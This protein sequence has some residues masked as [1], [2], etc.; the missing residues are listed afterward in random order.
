MTHSSTS[1][2]G[3]A[4]IEKIRTRWDSFRKL[5]NRP[6]VR[7]L[8]LMAVIGGMFA[9]M[10]WLFHE[11]MLLTNEVVAAET[12]I[13][14]VETQVA[15]TYVTRIVECEE[16][17]ESEVARIA[18]MLGAPTSCPLISTTLA[19]T[20]MPSPVLTATPTPPTPTATPTSPT[21][22]ATP[23]PPTPTDTPTPT[24]TPTNTPTPPTPEVLVITPDSMTC[25]P[26]SS[27]R[28]TVVIT[29]DNFIPAPLPIVKLRDIPATVLTAITQ[30]ITATIPY[31]MAPGPCNLTVIN[32][33]GGSNVLQDAFT[34]YAPEPSDPD[35][36]STLESS[37][38]VTFG[39][40]ADQ[41]LGD[42]DKVQLL[43]I[44][45]PASLTDTL[46]LRIFDADTGGPNVGDM[47]VGTADTT[48]SYTLYG[49]TNTYTLSEA[50]A[51]HPLTVGITS[52]TLLTTATF[53]PGDSNTQ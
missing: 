30:V 1:E 24:S 6:R 5:V 41:S 7:V 20:S 12:R 48:I 10:C 37:Y 52:G 19:D 39:R 26:G 51:A 43:F 17:C 3:T 36:Y 49:L 32:Y 42:D 28:L 18:R 38:L 46:H 23:T 40:D 50:R 8:L 44:E 14:V 53:V 27:D 33:N 21:P 15:A 34:V 45:V 16:R 25:I 9:L 29:G 4:R 2:P 35:R 11:N 47:I 31:S 13:V 22:T